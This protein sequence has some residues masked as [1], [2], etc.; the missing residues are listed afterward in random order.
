MGLSDYVTKN[1][2]EH[3]V[4]GISGGSTPRSSRAWPPTR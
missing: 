3:V 4:L 1:G 2:F